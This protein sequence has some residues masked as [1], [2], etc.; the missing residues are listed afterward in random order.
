M[1]TWPILLLTAGA[2]A[3]PQFSNLVVHE[4]ISDAP[5]GFTRLS[6]APANQTLNLRIA[7]AN[8]NMTGLEDML[9]AVSTPGSSQY[10]HFL[11]KEAVRAWP[12]HVP[13]Y[14]DY[15]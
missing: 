7:L 12:L 10:G 14:I 15:C 3:S 5:D 9:Y 2:Y 13:S 11:S 4:S 8:S 1:Y 6:S